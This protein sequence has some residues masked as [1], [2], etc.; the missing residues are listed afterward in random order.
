[1]IAVL[2]F[3]LLQTTSGKILHITKK[4]CIDCTLLYDNSYK[5]IK[6]AFLGERPWN[7]IF[8]CFTSI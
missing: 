3:R 2:G 7:A 6:I 8:M 5:M 4:L 1:M